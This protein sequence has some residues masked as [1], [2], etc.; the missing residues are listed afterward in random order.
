MTITHKAYPSWFCRFK[1][2]RPLPS[3]SW[4]TQCHVCTTWCHDILCSS[5]S[6]QH[7]PHTPVCQVCALDSPQPV[8]ASCLS[9]PPIWQA[10]ASAVAYVEPWRSLI[11]GFKFNEEAGL[12]AF[13]AKRMLANDTLQALVLTSSHLIPVPLSAKRLR[14]RGFNQASL[15]A[16]HLARHKCIDQGLLRVTDTASQASLSREQRQANLTHAFAVH[17]A[18]RSHLA[19]KH[20]TL[21][22]DVM[23]TG[24][25]L[26][27]CA[28][29]LL[30][31]GAT[32][33]DCVTLA[34]AQSV[35][36]ADSL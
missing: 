24:S 11:I 8:C 15:L 32:K 36:H 5:C 21:V 3:F 17:P 10:C 20:L 31:A 1:Q 22:D 29:A 9:S 35:P 16:Q 27:A 12:A 26:H 4:P 13:F 28:L 23:T 14:Q 30:Q 7:Q 33:V 6:L 18:H 2:W 25:T 34:R 19:G